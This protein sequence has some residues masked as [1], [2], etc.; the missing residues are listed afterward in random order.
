MSRESDPKEW[1]RFAE[2][3]RRAARHLLDAGDYDSCAFHCQQ[4]VEKFLKAI[5][6]QQTGERPPHVHDLLTLLRKVSGIETDEETERFIGSIDTYY[7]GTRYPLEVVDPGIFD[8]PLAQS[9]VDK[10][11]RI[12]QWFSTR[13]N[14]E[15]T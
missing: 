1:R 6:V 9:A 13:F 8:K 12:F 14:F 7:V 5:I 15:D 4:A 2:I 11:E 10:M 3:D